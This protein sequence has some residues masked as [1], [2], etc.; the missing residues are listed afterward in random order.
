MF[1]LLTKEEKEIVAK[2][3][4]DYK[5]PFYYDDQMPKKSRQSY[6]IIDF[7]NSKEVYSKQVELVGHWL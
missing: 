5:N 3:L 7:E 2:Q 6:L 4:S 1:S